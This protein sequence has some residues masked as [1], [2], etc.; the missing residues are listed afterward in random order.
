MTPP[1]QELWLTSAIATTKLNDDGQLH[2]RGYA[3]PSAHGLITKVEVSINRG[4]TWHDTRVIYS[5]GRWSWVIWEAFVNVEQDELNLIGLSRQDDN[6]E[7]SQRVVWCRAWNTCGEVQ[8]QM[9]TTPWNIRGMA[10]NGYGEF[11]L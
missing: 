4:R 9:G 1:L 10:Y 3:V 2:V 7:E 8:T 5:E 11:I 6:R